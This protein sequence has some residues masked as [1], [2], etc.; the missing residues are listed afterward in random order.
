MAQFK[1]N[2]FGDYY[3]TFKQEHH[4][5]PTP[6]LTLIYLKLKTGRPVSKKIILQEV[7]SR[8]FDSCDGCI[9]YSC[10]MY[11]TED[12]RNESLG[13]DI[14]KRKTY[15]LFYKWFPEMKGKV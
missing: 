15:E 13:E 7:R 1:E 3:I 12:F 14:L 2:S 8:L 6:F 9:F 10:E 5:V 4:V 11:L